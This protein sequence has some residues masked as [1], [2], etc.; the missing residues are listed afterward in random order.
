MALTGS[1]R[2]FGISEIFQLIGHQ[3]KTGTLEV[4]DQSRHVNILF[5]KGNI[6][7]V[8]H[9]PYEEAFDLG[10]MLVRSGLVSGRDMKEARRKQKDTLK[11]LEHHLLESNLIS[12]EELVSTVSL[13]N[14]E[15]IY[16]LF[17]WKDGDYSFEAGPVNYAHQW[18]RP[19]SSEQVLMDGYRIKDEWPVIKKDIPDEKL[20]LEKVPGEF[21]P[22]EKLEPEQQRIYGMVNGERTVDDLVYLS[23]MGRFETLK[24]IRE[25][26]AAGRLQLAEREAEKAGRDIKGPLVKAAAVIAIVVGISSIA[27]GGMRLLQERLLEKNRQADTRTRQALWSVYKRDGVA[28]ALSAYAAMEGRYPQKLEELL[29]KGLIEERHLRT[30]L[31]EFSYQAGEEGRT[32][33]LSLPQNRENKEASANE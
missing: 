19:I 12:K 13:A 23:R 27:V 5:E 33:R 15:V 25:L 14:L 32:C 31:G 8:R 11:P 30:A 10:N 21:G 1:M 7:D 17:L 24:T 20:L 9:E 3:Q 29:E 18:T 26:I 28:N 16:S 22:E 4:K 2:D 6:V